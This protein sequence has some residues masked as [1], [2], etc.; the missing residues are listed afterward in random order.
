MNRTLCTALS[1]SIIASSAGCASQAVK[2]PF[3]APQIYGYTLGQPLS[4]DEF[5]ALSATGGESLTGSKIYKRVDEQGDTYEVLLDH[6]I[7]PDLITKASRAF[8]SQPEC[9]AEFEVQVAQLKQLLASHEDRT[10]V[11]GDR[12]VSLSTTQCNVDRYDQSQTYRYALIVSVDTVAAPL[13]RSLGDK[14]HD[15]YGAVGMTVFVIAL[16]PF[17]LVALA[18]DKA[19]D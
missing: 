5:K 19:T 8:V 17:A 11:M 7:R 12:Y 2:E 6:Q 13:K 4:S 15:A 1:L 3:K 16:L 10:P 9:E 14:I 18:V